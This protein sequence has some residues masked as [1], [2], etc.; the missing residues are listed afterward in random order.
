MHEKPGLREGMD[1]GFERFIREDWNRWLRLRRRGLTGER[2]AT[3]VE[4]ALMASAIAVVAIASVSMVGE[5]S[6]DTYDEVARELAAVNIV[7]PDEDDP[8]RP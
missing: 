8:R 4:Y 1:M 2:G 6:A 3:M 5:R 7:N